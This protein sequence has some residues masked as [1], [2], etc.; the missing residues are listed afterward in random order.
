LQAFAV[1]NAQ[2]YS[3]WEKDNFRDY[4]VKPDEAPRE[5]QKTNMLMS[6]LLGDGRGMNIDR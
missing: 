3:V 5:L 2:F 1:F 6:T 4:L